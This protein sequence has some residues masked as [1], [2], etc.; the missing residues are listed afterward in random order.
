MKI[1][2]YCLFIVFFLFTGSIL[3][4]CIEETAPD[5]TG[6]SE[7]TVEDIA[8]G[9]MNHFNN[10]TIGQVYDTLFTEEVKAQASV[11]QVELIWS[12]I[13]AQYGKF[14]R[15]N[16]TRTTDEQGY[17]IV[18]VTCDY[19]KLGLLD[20]RIVFTIDK[21]I[22]GY[23]F[24]ATDVSSQYQP[25][26]Y[27]N[28][29]DFVE[30]NVTIGANTEWALPGT[31][32]IPK[33]EGPFPA[34]ILVHGS[35]PN[36][37]DE[38]I[39][40]NKPFKDLAWGLASKNIAVLR[41]EKRTKYYATIIVSV[42][43]ILTVQEET[44]SDAIAAIDLLQTYDTI[45]TGKIYVLG[46]SLGGMLAPRLANM[47]SELAGLIM[48]AAP[49]RQIEDLILNQ[50]IYLSQLD[51]SISEQEQDQINLLQEN[52]TKIKNLNISENEV[53][54]G[55][56]Y[57]Y[58]EDLSSYSPVDTANNLTLPLLIMQGERDYQVL[59][60]VDFIEWQNKLSDYTSISFYSYES[61]NHLFISGSGPPNNEEY[62]NPGNVAEEVILD[63]SNWIVVKNL[64]V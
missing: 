36:D 50:T 24:V 32:T 49:T 47:T 23:Q 9:L 27:A 55:A 10:G 1:K 44:I 30:Y 41:Y 31:L 53:I 11:Q 58:W 18:F 46:H 34:V 51:G 45:D 19:S 40:P 33:G 62:N 16:R 6:S 61:L 21:L 5:D 2:K 37:R 48:L 12:Q 3:T 4:G 35:G 22:A 17:T 52:I 60:E 57:A 42:L 7:E 56:G 43:S 38:T 20:T 28:V 39:G 29:N 64:D 8:R 13:T 54:L 25:P 59:Y 26:S 15:I 63:I 14:L